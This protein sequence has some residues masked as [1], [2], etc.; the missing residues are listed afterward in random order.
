MKQTITLNLDNCDDMAATFGLG[1]SQ[2]EFIVDTV[3]REILERP[4][5]RGDLG[6]VVDAINAQ[7]GLEPAGWLLLGMSLGAAAESL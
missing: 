3:A 1:E 7:G 5:S 2:V 6:T 4:G